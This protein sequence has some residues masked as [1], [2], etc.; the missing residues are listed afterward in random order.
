MGRHSIFMLPSLFPPPPS[1]FK[2]LPC[3]VLSFNLNYLEN[4]CVIGLHD[5]KAASA[6]TS[7]AWMKNIFDLSTPLI[8]FTQILY[9][10]AQ[11]AHCTHVIPQTCSK[12]RSEYWKYDLILTFVQIQ[13]PSF[14][15]KAGRQKSIQSASCCCSHC[16][17][18][19]C[20][21]ACRKLLTIR[22]TLRCIC[23]LWAW[24]VSC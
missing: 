13:L 19:L 16:D 18:R 6:H 24:N 14:I 23:L 8:I 17:L 15:R 11:W 7:C 22:T 4:N 2:A 21:I 10:N 5:P 20:P 3:A 9:G 1:H 12:N